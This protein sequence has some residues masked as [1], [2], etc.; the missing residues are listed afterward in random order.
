[1][2]KPGFA[3]GSVALEPTATND[4]PAPGR[5]AALCPVGIYN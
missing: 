1:M 4:A 5:Q 2:G 3:G